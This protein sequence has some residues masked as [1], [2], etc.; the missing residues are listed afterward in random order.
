MTKKTLPSKKI[1]TCNKIIHAVCF[2]LYSIIV[3]L[4]G[5]YLG[6]VPLDKLQLFAS[7]FAMLLAASIAGYIALTNIH[8]NQKNERIKAALSAIDKIAVGEKRIAIEN[9]C[10]IL[11]QRV[12]GE[13]SFKA[14][15]RLPSK[16]SE[17]IARFKNEQPDKYDTIVDAITYYDQLCYGMKYKI[18]DKELI[19]RFIGDHVFNAWWASVIIIRANEFEYLRN[20]NSRPDF[21]WPYKY[22]L[23]WIRETAKEQGLDVVSSVLYKL[24]SGLNNLEKNKKLDAIFHPK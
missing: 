19:E 12:D 2:F 6:G 7:P 5:F 16:A 4:F 23:E 17:F 13:H 1:K 8:K 21:D 11:N 10:N 20:K 9:A 22:L 24:D 15:A 14:L 18:Y 3:F